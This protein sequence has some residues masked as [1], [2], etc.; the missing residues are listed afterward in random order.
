MNRYH[1]GSSSIAA[2][3]TSIGSYAGTQ[4][5]VENPI[6]LRTICNLDRLLSFASVMLLYNNN[7]LSGSFD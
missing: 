1:R 6:P 5:K 7:Y 2:F 3:K 4:L